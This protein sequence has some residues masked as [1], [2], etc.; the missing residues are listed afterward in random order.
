MTSNDP[1]HESG[2]ESDSRQISDSEWHEQQNVQV[3]V[4]ND[5]EEGSRSS[6][7]LRILEP[8]SD[9]ESAVALS[10]ESPTEDSVVI[11]DV[12]PALVL[13]DKLGQV[14]EK[15]SCRAGSD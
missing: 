15:V 9:D 12:S 2:T 1:P 13:S 5:N 3:A 11:L 4:L 6:G 7:R 14:A 8:E 10:V